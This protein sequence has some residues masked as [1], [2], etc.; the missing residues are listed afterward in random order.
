MSL[1]KSLYLAAA[2]AVAALAGCLPKPDEP[3]EYLAREDAVIVQMLEVGGLAQSDLVG[4]LTLPAFTLYGDG[5]LIYRNRDA[6][7]AG[8]VHAEIPGG[9]VQDLLELFDGEG[10]F[11]FQYRQP[12]NDN[13]A[14]AETTYIY[15]Q[16]KEA[17][18][19]VSAYALGLFDPPD[20]SAWREF[21]RLLKIK[22]RLARFDPEAVGGRVIGPYEPEA[23][24]LV[25][26]PVPAENVVGSPP[27]WPVEAVDLR[28]IASP[29]SG[30][31]DHVV[32]GE[33]ARA[34]ADVSVSPPAGLP[35]TFSQ[36]GRFFN[37]AWRPL[38]PFENHFPEFDLPMS[39]GP[40]AK[41]R[42]ARLAFAS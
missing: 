34:F 3:V 31:V 35:V 37:V 41:A 16:T 5:T 33:A 2:V 29:E 8:I 13:V 42:R 25:V 30:R 12:I 38:L 17:A 32:E 9:A 10:F 6:S 4:Q 27:R 20:D 15:A 7:D 22:E 40:T 24:L 1:R 14:D 21:R 19:A 28:S 26:E 39:A 11:D 36:D 23:V 18:N